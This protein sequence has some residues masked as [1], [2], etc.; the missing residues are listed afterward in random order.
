[1]EKLKE[2]TFFDAEKR[3]DSIP[4]FSVFH[5]RIFLIILKFKA[6]IY[7]RSTVNPPHKLLKKWAP[8]GLAFFQVYW[9]QNTDRQYIYLLFFKFIEYKI[10]PDNIYIYYFSSLLNTKYRQTIYIFTIFQVYWI[11]NTDRQYIYLLFFKFTGYTIQT[12]NIYIFTIFQVY[13]I[14]N[15]DRQYIYIYYFSLQSTR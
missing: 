4:H 15:T 2:I 5:S 13:W 10:Q 12:D 7:F 6:H 1:M 14:Q 11:Q 3:R 8:I 9:I